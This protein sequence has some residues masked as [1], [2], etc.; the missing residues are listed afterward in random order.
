LFS[1]DLSYHVVNKL[2]HVFVLEGWKV[3]I[4]FGIALICAYQQE[5]LERDSDDI[6][7]Y[8]RRIMEEFN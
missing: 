7:V 4:K 1:E 2:W 6:F 8:M 5:I 3:F